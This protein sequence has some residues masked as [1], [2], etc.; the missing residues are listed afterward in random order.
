MLS[1]KHGDL[2]PTLDLNTQPSA[3]RSD[4]LAQGHRV[5][6]VFNCVKI[7]V[8]LWKME[9]DPDRGAMIPADWL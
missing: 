3:L 7:K 1:V 5:E 9:A 2:G 4:A 6:F 8:L